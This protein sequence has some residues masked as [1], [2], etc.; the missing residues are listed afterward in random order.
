MA[1]LGPWPKGINNLVS[2]HDVPRSTQGNPG[3]ACRNAVNIDFADSGKAK[4]RKGVT[5]V[6]SGMLP[7]GGF[8]CPAGAFFVESGWL[9]SFTGSA[10]VNLC[11]VFG[12]TFAYHYQ[13]GI[14]YFSDGLVCK[15]IVGGAVYN[16]GITPPS[17][18]V[19]STTS[20]TFAAGKYLGAVCF[21]DAN[22]VESGASSVV[23]V[24]AA[25]NTGI[26]FSNLASTADQQVSYLRLYLSMPDGSELYHVADVAPGSSPY[27]VAAGRY[28]DSNVLETAFVSPPPAGRIIRTH[29]GR[30]FV[31]DAS[32]AVWYSD[33][34]QPDHFRLGENFLAFPHPVDIM[35]PVAGGIFFAY[36]DK[37]EFHAGDVED[38]FTVSL[39]FEYGGIFGTGARIDDS[40][41]V[42]W[43]SQRGTIIGTSGGECKNIQE[44]RVAPDTGTLGASLVREIDGS[45]Q[46]VASI[47]Q[48]S[49]PKFAAASWIQ[50]ETTRRS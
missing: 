15:K 17:T 37:T 20:G 32:G 26:V 47:Q 11:Q 9:K 19:L 13:D 44:N 46:F 43:Q 1:T 4:R 25:S 39:K 16:W 8:S 7:K 49:L 5:K 10:G 38:G 23:S 36:G 24:D 2:D 27:T 34:F 41:T 29:N 35:E 6:Y 28:D 31:A 50:M 21:V 14:V 33:P 40:D 45:K 18:P 22:G 30:K 3:D 42:S 48:P 12:T